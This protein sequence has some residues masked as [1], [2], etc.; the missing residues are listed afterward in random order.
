MAEDDTN[1]DSYHLTGGQNTSFS[2]VCDIGSARRL[3]YAI[4]LRGVRDVVGYYSS[5]QDSQRRK[6][7]EAAWR[8]IHT[9]GD[10]RILT[11]FVGICV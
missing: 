9:D 2:S 1:F 3:L 4:L 7:A 6:D 11:T 10:E 5:P 8:W